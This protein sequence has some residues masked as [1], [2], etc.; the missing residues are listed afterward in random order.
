LPSD[1]NAIADAKSYPSGVPEELSILYPGVPEA[2]NVG[3]RLPTCALR[4]RHSK[5]IVIVEVNFFINIYLCLL[6]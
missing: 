1:V 3:S 6:E 5:V 4:Y 2:L